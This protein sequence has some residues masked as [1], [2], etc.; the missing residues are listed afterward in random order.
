MRRSL[1]GASGIFGSPQHL[2]TARGLAVG[3]HHLGRLVTKV[4]DRNRQSHK[5]RHPPAQNTDL[6]VEAAHAGG[7]RPQAYDERHE[8]HRHDE[9]TEIVLRKIGLRIS[10]TGVSELDAIRMEQIA[11]YRARADEYDQW[12]LRQGRYDRGP[13]ATR[14]WLDEIAQVG[15]AFDMLPFDDRDVLELAPGT[16]RWTERLAVRARRVTAIDT[17]VEMIELARQ[18]LGPLT[19]RVEFL[20]R[21]LLEWEP[22]QRHDAVVFCFWIS[23]VPDSFLDQFLA[24]VARALRRGGVVF[25]LDGRPDPMST[26]GD[27]VL[28]HP[29]EEVMTRRLNDGREFRIFKSFWPAAQLEARFAR[30]GLSIEINESATYFQY[31]CGTRR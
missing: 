9:H 11:Y 10:S 24:K 7:Y 16:G 22:T 23:H 5:P 3:R 31:G 13:D 17:S 28:P 6:G 19:D 29:G 12:W 26:A 8:R 20:I 25:F 30:A 15:A 18:R 1:P 14:R 4:V 21:D 27:H 2:R